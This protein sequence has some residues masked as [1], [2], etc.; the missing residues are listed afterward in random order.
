MVD[1][2]D[3]L[4]ALDPEQ[5]EVATTLRGPVRVLAGAGTGK[6]RAITH[7]I[8]YGVATGVYEPTEVLAVTFTTR[9][10]A[11]GGDGGVGVRSDVG[12]LGP[13]DLAREV[14][15]GGLVGGE[16]LAARGEGEH[17]Q[18]GLGQLGQLTLVDPR[19]EEPELAQ[20]GGVERPGLHS[21]RTQGPQP[22]AHLARRPRG[23]GQRED[24]G[25][26]VDAGGD[27]VG[28]AVGDRAGLAGAGPRE[29]PDGTPHGLGHLALLGIER[30]QQ[31]VGV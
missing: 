10:A 26:R 24:L 2:D 17:A 23:E 27:A 18:L 21:G 25:G 22:L 13:L 30:A 19:P 4:G 15:Q 31:S 11:G 6:T 9:A 7:R 12:D 29:H 1:A 8:A 14:A 20:G 5:R 28:D 3:L 16:P